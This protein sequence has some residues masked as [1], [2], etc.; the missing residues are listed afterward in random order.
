MIGSLLE[1]GQAPT[2]KARVEL[3]Q[4]I[5]SGSKFAEEALDRERMP[6]DRKEI[7]LRYFE[8]IRGK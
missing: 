3:E 7:P 1:K 8:R 2:G 5:L 4:L 6:A